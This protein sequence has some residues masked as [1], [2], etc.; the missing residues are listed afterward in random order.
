M[1]PHKTAQQALDAAFNKLG[2]A[3]CPGPALESYLAMTTLRVTIPSPR[4][5]K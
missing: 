5:M 2:P 1:T 4:L 3:A